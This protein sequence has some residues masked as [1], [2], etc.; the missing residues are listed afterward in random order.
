M[1]AISLTITPERNQDFQFL[2]PI[3]ED[4][5]YLV[6][7]ISKTQVASCKFLKGV[8]AKMKGGIGLWLKISVSD[9]Y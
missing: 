9:Y 5:I 8:F 1:A 6:S 2:H 7:R 4:G 3:G